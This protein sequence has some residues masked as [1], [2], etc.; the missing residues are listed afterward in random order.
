MLMK[1]RY[2]LLIHGFDVMQESASQTAERGTQLHSHS[3]LQTMCSLQNVGQHAMVLGAM[4]L[5]A[6]KAGLRHDLLFAPEV[7]AGELNE[8]V[9][10]LADPFAPGST[11]QREAQRVDGI[12]QD[13]VLVVHGPHAHATSVVPSKKSHMSLH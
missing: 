8:F 10:E 5:Q 3:V 4:F 12:H 2:I 6:L 7:H 11:H 1:P 9:Q 13:S